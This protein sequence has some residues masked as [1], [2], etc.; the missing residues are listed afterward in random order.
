MKHNDRWLEQEVYNA[1]KLDDMPRLKK[2][3]KA[4]REELQQ[5]PGIPVLDD[6][7]N[8]IDQLVNKKEILGV[9]R[10][11]SEGENPQ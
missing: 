3:F 1:I 5:L 8:E 7:D 6:D 11:A 4:R 2:A 10:N 9:M